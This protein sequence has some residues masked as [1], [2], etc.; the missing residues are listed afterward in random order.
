MNERMQG[1]VDL[2]P[3]S[4]GFQRTLNQPF[5]K[6]LGPE[7]IH[8]Y[9]S[10]FCTVQRLPGGHGAQRNSAYISSE[11]DG[12]PT[13]L[14][15]RRDRKRITVINEYFDIGA[16]ALC[17]MARHLFAIHEDV[18][19]IVLNCAALES[20]EMRCLY[21]RYNASE[22]IVISL[23][24]SPEAYCAALGRNTRAAI[25]RSQKLLS[26]RGSS[27]EFAFHEK[28]GVGRDRIAQ[29]VELSRLRIAGKQ[30][31]PTHSERSIADLLRMVDSHGVTLTAHSDGK[32]CGGVVC[33]QVG[34]HFYMHV[35]AHDRSF[36]DLR[37]GLLCCYLSICE[38]IRRGAVEY[39]LLSGRYDY[40]YRLLGKQRDF[41][42]IVVYRSP[43]RL[44]AHLPVY[45][46]TLV[47]GRGRAFK[48][49]W[50]SWRE[51]WKS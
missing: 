17:R 37:L 41:D 33:T 51:S 4:A 28:A 49:H 5:P 43:Q 14:L 20:G 34:S 45:L 39:H 27:L 13:I 1:S 29:L 44:A 7:L 38:A 35:I 48:Q 30:Q 26:E 12:A 23:P 18:D 16:D 9:Q 50:K 2:V 42:R 3:T 15:Y 24:E 19:V 11:G 47:R 8:R 21:Q 6:S 10:I 46:H 25:R 22:D 40:K 32:L 31:V 36:D